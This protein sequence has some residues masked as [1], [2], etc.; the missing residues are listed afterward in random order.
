MKET[1]MTLGLGY[2]PGDGKCWFFIQIKQAISKQE[3]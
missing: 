3:F 1:S 2:F